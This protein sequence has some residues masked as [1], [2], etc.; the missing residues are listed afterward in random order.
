MNFQDLRAE[1]EAHS[2]VFNSIQ[3]TGRKMMESIETERDRQDLAAKLDAMN[4][5]WAVLM[6][7]SQGVRKRLETAEEQWEKLTTT[8]K[9]LIFWSEQRD[10]ELLKQ[11]PIGGNLSIVKKQNDVV[12]RILIEMEEK[13]PKVAEIIKL[14]HGFLLQQDIRPKLHS[15]NSSDEDDDA[16]AD[17]DVK[18][19]ARRVALQI[20]AESDT[21]EDRWKQLS[22]KAFKSQ[23]LVEDALAVKISIFFH[24]FSYLLS[25]SSSLSSSENNL[26]R[27]FSPTVF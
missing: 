20:K 21:L 4:K 17:A 14:A 23:R 8:L 9:E 3:E 11:Q 16:D 1:I 19:A 26:S 6:K 22:E 13:Q 10:E 2:D 12:R 27:G 25:L 5:R 15:P 7:Q 24:I 18:K